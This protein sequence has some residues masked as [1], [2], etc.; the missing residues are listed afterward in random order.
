[1][2][3]VMFTDEHFINTLKNHT[4]SNFAPFRKREGLQETDDL[5]E[6]VYGSPESVPGLSGT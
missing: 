5:E 6:T 4:F 1:M 2:I 3:N